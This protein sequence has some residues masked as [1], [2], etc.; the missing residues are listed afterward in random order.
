M[1]IIAASSLFAC[2]RES[3]TKIS[4]K[5]KYY[6]QTLKNYAGQK[7]QVGHPRYD[8]VISVP[9]SS[10]LGGAEGTFLPL[11]ISINDRDTKLFL[12]VCYKYFLIFDKTLDL[13]F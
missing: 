3:Q 6:L 10:Y 9:T 11:I 7:G 4:K 5:H 13:G 12:S 1:D 2:K 8:W